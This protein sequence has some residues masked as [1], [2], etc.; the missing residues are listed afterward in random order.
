MGRWAPPEV[1]ADALRGDEDAADRLV[2]AVWPRCSRLAASIIGDWSLAQD[3]AQEA[4][5]ILHRKVRGL[6]SVAAFDSWMYR[7]VLREA[8]RV[9]RSNAP[10]EQLAEHCEGVDAA[11]SLDVWRALATLPPKL[12]TVVVLFYFDALTSEEIAGILRVPHATVRTRLL[13]ARDRLRGLL[14]DYDDAYVPVLEINHH[15]I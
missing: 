6:R 2:C 1:V 5:V 7:I 10:F 11:V 3:A 12:R 15:A 4:C 9:R 13:R 14:R 8:S